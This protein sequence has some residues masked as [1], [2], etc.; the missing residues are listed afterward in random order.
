MKVYHMSQTLKLGDSLTPDYERCMELSQPFIQA[1]ERSED[2]FY[3]MVLNGRYLNAVLEKLRLWEWSDYAKWS[4]EGAFEFIRRREYPD[5]Y[6]RLKSNFFY[7]DPADSRRL[8]KYDWGNEPEE[9]QSKVHLYEIEL[10]DA[11]FQRRDMN[12]YDE[13]YN[14]MLEKQDIQTV[15]SCARR[16]FAGEQTESPVWE[17]LS[18]KS[19]RAAADVT[20]YLRKEEPLL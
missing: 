15:F 10:E 17:I 8:F 19:A 14:A 4:T 12:I 5:C 16:Y 11:A 2:C 13:A 1:L 20:A 6:S 3:T 9:E 7:E 18:D